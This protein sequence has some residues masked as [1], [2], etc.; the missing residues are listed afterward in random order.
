M[1]HWRHLAAVRRIE[2]FFKGF[3]IQYKE[4]T[5]NLEADELAKVVAKKTVIP[6]DVFFQVI[7]DPS[8]K[9][10]KPEPRMVNV[11]QGE[12]WRAPTMAYHCSHYETDTNAELI[13]MQQRAK[14]YQVIGELYKTLVIGPLLSY[15]S[16]DEGKDL[17]T[18]I[19]AGA[20]RGHIGQGPSLQKCSGRV[21]IG[22]P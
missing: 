6:L 13:R 3:T 14:V 1:K 16:K 12:N 10:I 17:L 7:E 19:H 4:R 5:K 2:R 22:H 9:T 20:C 18:Q 11:V 21:S 8:M 15:L